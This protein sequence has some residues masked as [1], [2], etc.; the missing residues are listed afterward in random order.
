MAIWQRGT[1]SI[2]TRANKYLVDR[3]KALSVTDGDASIHQHTNVPTQVQTGGVQFAYS[4]RVNCTTADTS[5]GASQYIVV[6]QRVEGRNLR[7]LGFG[8]AGTRYATLQFWQRSPAG[9]YY[10]SFR[11]ASY[12]RYYLGSYTIASANTWEKHVITIPID[13]SG[14]WASDHSTGLDIQWS[15][16]NGSP[17][18]TVGSWTGGSSHA[19]SGQFN[20]FGTV[21]NDFY[22]TGVQFEAGTVATPFESIDYGSELAKCQRYYYPI[23]APEGFINATEDIGI[24]WANSN[25]EVQMRVSPPAQMRAT[26]SLEQ[27]TST[28]YWRIGGGNYGGDKYISN[29]WNIN[30][31]SPTGG[32]LYVAP[33]TGLSSYIGEVAS[34]QSKSTSARMALQSEL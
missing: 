4:L 6:S 26:P 1:T 7:H 30:N 27:T 3:F 8:L 15:L 24:G 33:D 14:T 21:G 2:N 10:V 29:S 31:M 12:N 19:G 25:T 32:N 16:G 5:L 23:T 28:N 18:G 9:T 22:L 13:T 11:N 34:I 20:F 17:T